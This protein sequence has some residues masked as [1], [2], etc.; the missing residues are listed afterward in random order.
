MGYT[1]PD[2]KEKTKAYNAAYRAKNAEAERAYRKA[3]YAANKEK[4]RA[5]NV[6]AYR[7]NKEQRNADARAAWAAMTPEKRAAVAAAMKEWGKQNAEHLKI[8][9][10]EYQ[11]NRAQTD[12]VFNLV[13]RQATRIR[14]VLRG[15]IK[16]AKTMELV[17]LTAT[18]LRDYLQ[19]KFLPGMTWENRRE[20]HIDHIRPCASF[21]LTDP[22]QQRICFHYTNLQ[23]LWAK[24]NLKKSDRWAA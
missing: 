5:M 3:Y 22:E 16:S 2:R 23:P 10:R 13:R 14:V 8:Y 18:E 15:N 24:D 21:D 1:G 7:K 6:A 9:R 4:V 19:S 17:G 20:W 11:R 12:P